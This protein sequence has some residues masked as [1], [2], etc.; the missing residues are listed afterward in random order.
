M[1]AALKNCVCHSATY[2]PTDRTALSREIGVRLKMAAHYRVSGRG[3]FFATL[4]VS[5]RAPLGFDAAMI[6]SV[7]R[8]SLSHKD[9]E[10]RLVIALG[11]SMSEEGRS[12]AF[13]SEGAEKGRV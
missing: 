11:D 10:C 4:R 8:N 9:G 3:G 5:Q 1:M 13:S 7:K 12:M 2:V 6:H